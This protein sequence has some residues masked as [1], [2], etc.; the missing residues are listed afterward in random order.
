MK[1]SLLLI[2]IIPFV[3]FVGLR[4]NSAPFFSVKNYHCVHDTLLSDDYISDINASLTEL[5]NNNLSAHG[6]IDHLQKQ[7]PV[8]KK[9]VISYQP[10]VVRVMVSAHKPVCSVNNAV[11]LTAADELF[12]KNSF[13]TKVVE[14]ISNITVTQPDVVNIPVAVS[15][16]MQHVPS[17]T[18]HAYNCEL[19]NE[20]CVRLIDKKQPNFTIVSSIDQENLPILLAQCDA[21]KHTIDARGEF[22]KGKKWIADTRFAH[23]IVAYKS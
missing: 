7:F 12:P 21:V 14:T 16:L 8:L 18:H 5:F 2:A 23:Y 3:I 15:R 10:S 19:I 1:K 4:W 20:H 17:Q 13:S 22:D 9:I 6:I 11:I